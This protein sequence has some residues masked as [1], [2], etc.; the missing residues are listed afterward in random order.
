MANENCLAGYR[1]PKCGSYGPFNMSTHCTTVWFDEGTDE[2]FDFEIDGRG[3]CHCLNCG[4]FQPVC[5]FKDPD[6][7]NGE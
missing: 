6:Y 3:F 5:D 7:K 1:C 2:S 4:A